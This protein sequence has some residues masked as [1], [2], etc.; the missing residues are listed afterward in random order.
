MA[1]PKYLQ[2]SGPEWDRLRI[3]VMARDNCQCQAHRLGLCAEPCTENRPRRL[4]VHHIQFRINGGSHDM[5]NL[6]TICKKHHADIHP[7][8]RFEL[9]M[10]ERTLGEKEWPWREL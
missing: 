5:D 3:F 9:E 10:V 4:E 2:C 1:R 8:M 6:I 7:H